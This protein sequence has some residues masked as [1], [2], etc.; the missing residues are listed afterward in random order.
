MQEVSV[1]LLEFVTYHG[2]RVADTNFSPVN[3]YFFQGTLLA[4]ATWC[5]NVAYEFHNGGGREGRAGEGRG[6]KRALENEKRARYREGGSD[7]KMKNEHETC[8][9]SRLTLES[10]PSP[11]GKKQPRRLFSCKISPAKVAIYGLRVLLRYSWC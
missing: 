2:W 9:T 8:V 4:A 11:I 7:M 3:N 6:R 10:V 5:A 1:W